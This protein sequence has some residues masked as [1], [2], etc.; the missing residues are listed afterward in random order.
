M[1]GG[2]VSPSP[3]DFRHRPYN[4]LACVIMAEITTKRAKP[5]LVHD[6]HMYRFDKPSADDGQFGGV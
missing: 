4:T 6:G 1:A 5:A 2:Q 3:I